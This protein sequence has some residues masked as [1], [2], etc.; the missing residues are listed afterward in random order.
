M[1]RQEKLAGLLKRQRVFSKGAQQGAKQEAK[2]EVKEEVKE[3]AK[4]IPKDL[5]LKPGTTQTVDPNKLSTNRQG[6]DRTRL[7][8]QK[9]LA[10]KGVRRKTNVKVDQ[11]GKVIDGN[12]GTKAY[13]E[14][15]GQQIDADVIEIP[16]EPPGSSFV[17]DLPIHGG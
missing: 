14:Y 17:K 7:E 10:D 13:S 9:E 5:N 6:L 4:E 2:K 12:H 8:K 1:I 15:P 11:T 16:G 3:D